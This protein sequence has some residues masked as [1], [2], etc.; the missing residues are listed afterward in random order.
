MPGTRSKCG[1]WDSDVTRRKEG[2]GVKTE[3]AEEKDGSKDSRLSSV[4][5]D[6]P[7]ADCL[8]SLT[9]GLKEFRFH[10]MRQMI[11]KN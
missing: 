6:F 5:I 1:E 9:L 2:G 11:G 4:C 3:E 10:P 8:S 7:S